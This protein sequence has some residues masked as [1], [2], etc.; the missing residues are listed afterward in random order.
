MALG[1]R[2]AWRSKRACRVSPWEG[3]SVTNVHTLPSRALVALYQTPAKW[4]NIKRPPNGSC[5]LRPVAKLQA[6]VLRIMDEG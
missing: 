2:A 1:R 6:A 3:Y 5:V 4:L